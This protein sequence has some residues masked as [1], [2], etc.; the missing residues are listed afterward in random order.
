MLSAVG[1]RRKDVRHMVVRKV[2]HAVHGG[3]YFMRKRSTAR[4][5]L[6]YFGVI[7]WLPVFF[8]LGG[9]VVF[10]KRV[11]MHLFFGNLTLE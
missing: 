1:G 8:Q 3:A 6:R 4:F 10:F 2:G 11:A 9:I 5:V 7:E